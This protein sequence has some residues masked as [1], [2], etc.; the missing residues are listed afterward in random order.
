[1][2]SNELNQLIKLQIASKPPEEEI[3]RG[4]L[5]NNNTNQ[6]EEYRI[7]FGWDI[8]TAYACDI[9]WN[10][11][12]LQIAAHLDTLSKDEREVEENKIQN[13]DGHWK[14]LNKSMLLKN[15]EYKWFFL[16]IN[17]QIQSACLIY[18]PKQSILSTQN[19][20]YIEFIAVAPWNRYHPLGH[21][22]YS[23]V[24]TVFLKEIMRHCKDVLN[25]QPGMCLHSLPQAQ[26]FYEQKLK[27]IHYGQA[28]KDGLWYYEMHEDNY[29]DF[30]RAI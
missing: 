28:D 14:W 15:D 5:I 25:F 11:F 24:G 13:E 18:H 6:N 21:K 19:V 8:F 17:N 29:L 30:V 20:F 2:D 10:A 27:M 12:R 23:G 1:M 9:E 3:A 7:T 22:T 16:R 4:V 26:S